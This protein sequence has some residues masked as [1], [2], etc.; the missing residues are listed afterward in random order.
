MIDIREIVMIKKVYYAVVN[1]FI[2]AA[3]G[4]LKKFLRKHIFKPSDL[5]YKTG[6]RVVYE[7]EMNYYDKNLDPVTIVRRFGGTTHLYAIDRHRI[8]EFKEYKKLPN[9]PLYSNFAT[10]AM[11]ITDHENTKFGT[12]LDSLKKETKK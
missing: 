10:E 4:L 11:V 8:L 1:F 12:E 7:V 5:I 9:P 3:M 6:T 2:S